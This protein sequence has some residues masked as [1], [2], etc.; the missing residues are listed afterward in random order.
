MSLNNKERQAA[1]AEIAENLR[2]AGI[3]EPALQALTG[4]PDGRFAAALNVT[5]A[6]DPADVWLVRDAVVKA[7]VD[8]GAEPYPFSK[9]ADS[10]R[11]AAG[12]WFGYQRP[13]HLRY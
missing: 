3:D 9:M 5:A 11:D 1:A 6:C 12:K 10:M 13:E 2:R 7:V 8:A 4:L